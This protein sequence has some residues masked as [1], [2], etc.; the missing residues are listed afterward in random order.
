MRCDGYLLVQSL[1]RLM[2]AVHQTVSDERLLQHLLQGGV[3]V[4]RATDHRS[5]NGHIT[6]YFEKQI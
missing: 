4:H 6:G 3:H 2:D 5:D 1:A